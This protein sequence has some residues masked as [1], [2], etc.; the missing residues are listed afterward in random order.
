MQFKFLQSERFWKLG[1]V[2][3]MAGLEEYNRTDQWERALLIAIGIW[4]GGS[5]VVRT[6]DRASEKIGGTVETV[7]RSM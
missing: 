3:L 5:V 1:L 2:G 6:A 7:G 4:L